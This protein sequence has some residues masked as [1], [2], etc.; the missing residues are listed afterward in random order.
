MQQQAVYKPPVDSNGLGIAGFVISLVGLC[1]GGVLSPIGLIISLIAVGRPPRGF[2]IAGIILGALGSCGILLTLLIFPFVLVALLAAAGATA[3][4]VALAAALGIP[5]FQAQ[6]EMGLLSNAVAEYERQEGQLPT[7]L[8][9]L[10]RAGYLDQYDEQDFKV[11]VD[12]WGNPYE[13]EVVEPDPADPD[14]PRFR[15]Y[16]R[17][18]DGQAG[19]QDDIV[20]EAEGWQAFFQEM[21]RGN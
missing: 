14:A 18:E 10:E 12:H 5:E 2:A 11:L 16:S 4:A 9:D 1:S 20:F 6:L 3:G 7:T 8:G 19:T 21:D 13:Y 15:L 17:G